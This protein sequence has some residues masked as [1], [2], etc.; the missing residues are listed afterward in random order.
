VDW[1]LTVSLV[2]VFLAS[3]YLVAR[4]VR[5]RNSKKTGCAGGCACAS[6]ADAAAQKDTIV[7]ISLEKLRGRDQANPSR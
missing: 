5:L 7:P 4:A 6:A 1:Q 3:C 2:L